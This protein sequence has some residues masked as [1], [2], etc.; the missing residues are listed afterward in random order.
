MTLNVHG[1][2]TATVAPANEMVTGEVTVKVPPHCEEVAL[3]TVSPVGSVSLKPTPVN[4]AG[5]PVGLV[6]VN[7]SE[8]VALGEMAVGLNDFAIEGGP[9]TLR[10]ADAVKPLPPLVEVTAPV[11]L[12]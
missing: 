12:V 11:V 4:E 7:V 2:P 3:V 10:L 6:T 5:L 8:V 1:V 9:S